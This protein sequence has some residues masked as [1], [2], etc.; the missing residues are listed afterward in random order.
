MDLELTPNVAEQH[1]T[2]PTKVL[3]LSASADNESSFLTKRRLRSRPNIISTNPKPQRGHFVP[4]DLASVDLGLCTTSCS[5][6]IIDVVVQ[7]PASHRG[8]LGG[9][10][11]SF[12][13][14]PKLHYQR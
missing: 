5:I 10:A 14:I 1:V 7:K 3:T 4:T 6:E 11:V 12:Q 8:K 9:E 2:S 13:L